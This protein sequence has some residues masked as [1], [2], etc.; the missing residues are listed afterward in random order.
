MRRLPPLTPYRAFEAAARLLS[1]R[2]AARELHVTPSAISH[3][4]RTL[5]EH[6]GVALFRRAPGG[7]ELTADAERILPDATA[8]LNLIAASTKIVTEKR[9]SVYLHCSTS[10][11]L[12]W[13]SRHIGRFENAYPNIL[14]RLSTESISDSSG[15]EHVD[16]EVQY[17]EGP[18]KANDKHALL[19]EWLLPVCS[20]EYLGG[21]RLSPE[22]LMEKRLITN[23]QSGWEWMEWCKSFDVSHDIAYEALDLATR[24][25]VDAGA[26]SAATRGMGVALANLCYV[27]PE[28]DSGVLVAA[29]NCEPFELGHHRL[30]AR[31]DLTAFQKKFVGWLQDSA[32]DTRSDI[33]SWHRIST[34]ANAENF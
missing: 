14:V 18:S 15:V 25:D 8:A 19:P 12:H 2:E 34:A 17:C 23:N 30:V 10:F 32:T 6:L 29:A 24:F 20:P 27:K 21:E 4:V 11:A 26:I 1:F 16:L 31:V 22:A 5:E 13:A 3:Q 33:E 9:P 28:L 7:V